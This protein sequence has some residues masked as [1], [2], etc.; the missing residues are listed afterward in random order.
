MNQEKKQYKI[1][2]PVGVK[3]WLSAEAAKN[4]RSISS[5]I[6]FIL[7]EKMSSTQ[8]EKSGTVSEA[9]SRSSEHQT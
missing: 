7:N 4:M 8:N 1:L 3:D 9:K 6:I 2:M 5:E